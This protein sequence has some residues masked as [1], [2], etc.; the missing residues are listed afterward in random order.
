[1]AGAHGGWAQGA[2]IGIGGAQG[3]WAQGA[4]IGIG[5]AQGGWA[6]GAAIGIGGA[7]GG[8]AQGA[9]IGIGG[10]IGG[11][12]GGSAHG[13]GPLYLFKAG[14]PLQQ[15]SWQAGAHCGSQ[16]PGHKRNE[17]ATGFAGGGAAP[18]YRK[19]RFIQ[20]VS[21][22]VCMYFTGHGLSSFRNKSER[23]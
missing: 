10:G 9:A 11:I 14:C 13:G 18:R 16:S 19:D 2:A 5:G 4:A 21:L 6:Q 12:H 3:G 1:M 23:Y 7:Q 20:S 17:G 15:K 8:W 22:C